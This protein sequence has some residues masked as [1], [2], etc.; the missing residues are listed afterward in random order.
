MIRGYTSTSDGVVGV[1][2]G[3]E[4]TDGLVLSLCECW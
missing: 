2:K 3:H 4:W 1:R